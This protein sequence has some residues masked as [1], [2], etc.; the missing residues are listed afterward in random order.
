LQELEVE[1]RM[2][3]DLSESIKKDF[4]IMKE[5]EAHMRNTNESTNSRVL[6]F[7]AFGFLWLT[8][9]ASWQVYHLWCYFK[10]KKLIS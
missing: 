2:L 6:G 3:E 4:N 7:S 5:R 10:A 8:A 1:L 9:V